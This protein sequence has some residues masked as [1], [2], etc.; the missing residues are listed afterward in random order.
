MIGYAGTDEK[1]AWL[2]ELGFDHAFNY[3]TQ[4]LGQTLSQAAPDG[5]D[6]Y[7]D[8][9]RTQNLSC[10]ILGVLFLISH[11]IFIDRVVRKTLRL[12]VPVHLSVWACM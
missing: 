8:N 5:I 11:L 4:D 10:V 6:V 9:V 2:K 1:V 12:V 7:Y 3:K